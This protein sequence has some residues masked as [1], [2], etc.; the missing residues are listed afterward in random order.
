[1]PDK[2][3]NSIGS[4][5]RNC[6][7]RLDQ[8]EVLSE[9]RIDAYHF[10]ATWAAAF[11]EACILWFKDERISQVFEAL[12]KFARFD[13]EHVLKFI[14]HYTTSE[15]LRVEIERRR[16]ECRLNTLSPAFFRQIACLDEDQKTRVYR[17]LFEL[18]RVTGEL[19][20]E[21]KRRIMAMKFHPDRGGS[22]NAMSV[23]NA[24]YEFLM[25]STRP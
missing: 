15:E 10:K 19:A 11:N 23:V 3:H 6:P 18:D 9:V 14:V 5:T 2:S 7:I 12:G 21:C 1:V 16:F 22:Q 17:D 13:R 24:A 20:L 4:L 8:C 25:N